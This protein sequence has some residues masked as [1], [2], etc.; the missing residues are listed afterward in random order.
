MLTPG[1]TEWLDSVQEEIL[2]PERPIVDPHHHLWKEPTIWGRYELD[3]LWADTG[4]GHNI[5]KTV[6]IDCRSSWRKDGPKHLRPVGETEYVA[7][8]AEQSGTVDGKATIAA[9]VSHADMTLGD[10]CEEVLAAHEEAGRGLFR[11]IRHAGPH[12]ETGTLRNPGRGGGCPYSREDFREGVR[13][14]GRLGYS[15]DTWHFHLQNRECLELARAAPDTTMILDHFGTPLR[16][17]RLRRA[18]GGDLHAVARGHRRDRRV[19]QRLRQARRAGD[20]R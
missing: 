17:R 8:V 5:E 1:T 15:Y 18:P 2:E 3:D 11:G 12:D 14:L 4:S 9:I 7:E 20:A 10:A 19:R 6:F 16:R 13:T